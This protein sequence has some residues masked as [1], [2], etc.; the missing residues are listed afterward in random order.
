MD[1]PT[2]ALIPVLGLG[3]VRFFRKKNNNPKGRWIPSGKQLTTVGIAG[4]APDL[5][6]PHLSLAARYAS[7]SHALWFWAALTLALL[8][9]KFIRPRL[10]H[11]PLVAWL[12]G[13][14]LLHLGCDTISGGIVWNCPFSRQVIG[15][16][17][18]I[19]EYWALLDAIFIL[20]CYLLF[21][22]IPAWSQVQAK[23]TG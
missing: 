4:A 16:F 23:R 11:M 17:Y 14:Y 20:A 3:L 13:A 9:A 10:L 15:D 22:A 19:P 8:A 21:R 2:H 18:V 12:P 7:Y 6:H 1:V 5:L